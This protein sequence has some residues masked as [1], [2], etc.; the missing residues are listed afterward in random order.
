MRTRKI[1]YGFHGPDDGFESTIVYEKP[2]KQISK[3]SFES[4]FY[5]TLTTLVT[6][7]QIKIDTV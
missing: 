3:Y 4:L 1:K 5:S 6:F 2:C 7:N